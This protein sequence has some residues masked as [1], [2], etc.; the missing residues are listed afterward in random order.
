MARFTSSTFGKISG[1]HGSAVAAV[2]KDGLCILKEYRVAS[3]PNTTGQKN[4]RGKF[5]FVMKEINCLRSVFTRNFGGQ[6]GINKVV[7]I[8]MKTAVAGEFPD[9]TLDYRKLCI[10]TGNL[11][12]ISDVSLKKSTENSWIISWN[13]EFYDNGA[14]TDKVHV[15]ILNPQTK[16]V[17]ERHECSNR[18]DGKVEIEVPA[19][20]DE[21]KIHA[22]IYLSSPEKKINSTSQYID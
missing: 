1:K 7:A 9:F 5:G 13:S 4:Q 3:N 15:V 17:M 14:P 18:S 12:S 22:W 10:A 2:R 16:F 20:W 6:Y 19:G 21:T 11:H 8:A